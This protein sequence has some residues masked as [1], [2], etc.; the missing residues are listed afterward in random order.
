MNAA[1]T[2]L[3]A[4]ENKTRRASHWRWTI[5]VVVA[6]M[7]GATAAN[8]V[9]A[10]AANASAANASA[11][12][13]LGLKE[14][15]VTAERRR[16]SA[17]DVPVAISAFSPTQLAQA[18]VRQAGD[19]A[20]MVPNLMVG[21]P[22][23]TE[24]QPVFS[25][26]GITTNDFSQ[27]QSS[28]IAMYVD[29]AY[30]PVGALQALQTFDL[31]RVEVLRGPQGTLYG[32]NATGGAVSFFSRDPSL[33]SYDGYATV[34]FGNYDGRTVQG[35]V[36]GPIVEDKLGW[37]AAVY[38][39][40]RNGWLDSII[41]GV[42]AENGVDAL[43]GRLTFLGKP[44][45]ELTINLKISGS[46]SGGTPYGV[47]PAN[48]LPAVTDS[49]PQLGAFQNAA[50]YAY[51]KS[52]KTFGG[53]L[54]IDWDLL[55]HARL[56]SVTASDYGRWFN[57]GDDG[58]VGSQIWGPDTY[59]SSV[60][61]DSQ[62]F[63][64]ASVNTTALHWIG[65]LY[66]GHYV[67]HG[68]TQY[69]YFDAFPGT[70]VI[71]GQTQSLYGFNQ[72][73]SYDQTRETR[74]AYANVSY[75]LTRS[76]TLRG[77]L[78]YTI[79]DISVKNFY[80]LEG[81]L[82][83]PP[84]CYCINMPTWWTQTIP[85]IPGTYVD[86]SQGIY[87][88]SAP[89]P[90]QARK[91]DNASYTAGVDWK[92]AAGVLSYVSVSTGYRGAAFNSQ[93]FNAPVEV[94]FAKPETLTAYEVG[95]KSELAHH[96]VQLNAALFYYN[97]YNQQFLGTS[98]VNGALFYNEINAP[99]SALK[100]GEV[101]FRALVTDALEVHATAGLQDDKYTERFVFDGVDVDGNQL[102][103]APK[104]TSTIG[105]NYK[106]LGLGEGTLTLGADGRYSSRIFWD[107]A[108]TERVAQGSYFVTNANATYTFGSE[109][110]YSVG[111]WGKNLTNRFYLAYALATQQPNQGG[112]GLDYTNPA[113]P[114]TFGINGTWNF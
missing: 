2:V 113:E 77:G 12:S 87:E 65:G 20:Q 9:D 26:R 70:I 111:L 46:N 97:Y 82:E 61:S 13:I 1:T 56:T 112:L 8:A 32:M 5:A 18:G 4:V 103:L 106:I 57:V 58:A 68:W 41:P 38:Y 19:I 114:R 107:P 27:N 31:A 108:D 74:A 66:F 79:D 30:M 52:I 110:Q 63:R 35:A 101:E 60:H 28:P 93:A 62:E 6:G 81:G 11:N 73:N 90:E 96:R 49:N 86:F 99:R 33:T 109:G 94:N 104:A 47:K 55:S 16:Q 54:K 34:G 17:Q 23:G 76:V 44:T 21:T 88:R 59:A 100:G 48:I 64:L 42:P 15:V 105:L 50:L 39:D 7:S 78:R 3:S 10:S 67:V 24:A 14:I 37:R 36:G 72:A 25:L 95:L 89:L 71:P 53:V 102:P 22:Y 80:A 84:T 69:N 91:N 43:A 29:E 98:T 75:D 83:G 51:D 45:D 92:M 40:K 85:V